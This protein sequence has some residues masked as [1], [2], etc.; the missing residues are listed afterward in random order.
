MERDRE[1][2]QRNLY[3]PIRKPRIKTLWDKKTGNVL[4]HQM[5]CIELRGL[6]L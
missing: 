3:Y 5:Q 2:N 1:Y 4:P 6:E